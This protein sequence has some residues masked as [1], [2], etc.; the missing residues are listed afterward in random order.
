MS[1]VEQISFEEYVDRMKE[2]QNDI[3]HITGESIAVV[4]SRSFRE[5]LRKKGHEVLRLADP[6]D[7][8]V[9]QQLKEFDGTKLK[10]TMKEGLDLGDQDEKKTLKEL[11]I[12][13]EPWK[14]LMKE[15]LGDKVEEAI[16]ND[17]I[18]DSLR[19]LTMSGH[20][21]SANMERIM[22][23]QA[24][25]DDQQERGGRK[26]ESE[27]VEGEEWETVVGKRR[28]NGKREKRRDRREKGGHT[29]R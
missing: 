20:G 22:K 14:K 3:Y 16:V 23:A 21:L 19:V 4:S 13:S 8:Y 5:H 24:S 17:R 9:V 1:G 29:R 18:V 11:K 27:K 10:P 25:R 7:E 26:E 6:V 2:G 28:K 12:E 15:A